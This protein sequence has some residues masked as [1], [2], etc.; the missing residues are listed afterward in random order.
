[1]RG[2]DW[3]R[4]ILLTILTKKMSENIYVMMTKC[5]INLVDKLEFNYENIKSMYYYSYSTHTNITGCNLSIS[6][7]IK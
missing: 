2:G 3:T 4:G 5:D 7:F 6:E 1:M